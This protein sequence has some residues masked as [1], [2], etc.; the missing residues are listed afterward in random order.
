M[1]TVT[2]SKRN[3]HKKIEI[4]LENDQSLFYAAPDK[5]C[6]VNPLLRCQSQPH[7]RK[8]NLLN[9]TA[10]EYS[11]K[12]PDVKK[13]AEYLFNDAAVRVECVYSV[14]RN[15]VDVRYFNRHGNVVVIRS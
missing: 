12:L 7:N 6:T 3:G 10:E 13:V 14:V 8:L 15:R 9:G 2:C 1:V 5:S 11:N 4:I